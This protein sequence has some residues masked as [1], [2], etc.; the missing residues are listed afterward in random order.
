M[1]KIILEGMQ[2]KS[3]IGVHQF[4]QDRG[5]RFEI[6]LTVTINEPIGTID[7]IDNTLDYTTLYLI[8]QQVMAGR[9]QL[10]E[11]AG[12]AII[13]GIRA[14]FPQINA[15]TLRICKL[16]PPLGGAVNRVCVELNV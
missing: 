16:N 4:E 10:I 9:Y 1:A 14:A 12:E 8:T 6:D 7:N 13:A 2:F 5:N 15:V 3:F 11:S